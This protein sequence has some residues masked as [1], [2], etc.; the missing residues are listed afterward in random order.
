LVYFNHWFLGASSNSILSLDTL[1]LKRG[2]PSFTVA[3]SQ[4][5]H[6]VLPSGC[7]SPLPPITG[8]YLTCDYFFKLCTL[9]VFH[10]I[11]E[12]SDRD[13]LHLD[14]PIPPPNLGCYFILSVGTAGAIGREVSQI[15][16][17][18]YSGPLHLCK[19]SDQSRLQ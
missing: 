11:P 14:C 16:G 3:Y 4:R 19:Y 12:A 9:F 13:Y 15:V 18:L 2:V 6:V 17:G 1:L 7:R 5:S 8:P 10:F